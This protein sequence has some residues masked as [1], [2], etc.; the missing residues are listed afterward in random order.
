MATVSIPGGL[1]WQLLMNTLGDQLVAGF[2]SFE[3]LAQ[4]E[5]ALYIAL[6]RDGPSEIMHTGPLSVTTEELAAYLEV[7]AS[8]AEDEPL[9]VS[10]VDAAIGAFLVRRSSK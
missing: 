4:L 3:N 10:F 8:V 6:E 2:G 1:T 7:L 9:K 5:E